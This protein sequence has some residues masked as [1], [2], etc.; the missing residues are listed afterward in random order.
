MRV[1]GAV[2]MNFSGAQ[3]FLL[4]LGISLILFVPIISG[5][6]WVSL[7]GWFFLAA[8]WGTSVEVDGDILRLKYFFGR[9]YSEVKMGDVGEVKVLTRLENGIVAREF[10]GMPILLLA[11][12]VGTFV[13]FVFSP[14]ARDYGSPSWFVLFATGFVYIASMILP[15]KRETQVFSLLVFVPIAG[16]ILDWLEPGFVD[17]FSIFIATLMS[18]IL[19][20][21]YYRKDYVL[22]KTFK[23]SYLVA[24]D[25]KRASRFLREMIQGNKEV[26]PNDV[27]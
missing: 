4:C 8:S 12:I 16:F 24:V 13:G 22:L 19:L 27:H 26:T 2:P 11:V 9:L 6:L 14:S 21:E 7:V 3:F 15:F 5:H 23:R 18:L 20:V 25:E 1:S 10:P 17:S